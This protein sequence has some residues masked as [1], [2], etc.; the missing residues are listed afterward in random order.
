MKKIFALLIC[1]MLLAPVASMAQEFTAQKISDGDEVISTLS[2]KV[3][4][5]HVG[6]AMSYAVMTGHQNGSKVYGSSSQDTKIFSQS[7]ATVA[8]TAPS[9]SDSGAFSGEAWKAL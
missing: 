9:S 2:N 8:V 3:T 4:L 7:M 1:A 6:G 5:N